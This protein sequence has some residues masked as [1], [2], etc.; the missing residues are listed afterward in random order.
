MS[1]SRKEAEKLSAKIAPLLRSDL[2]EP[3][4]EAL[5]QLIAQAF[6]T[7]A[8][9]QEKR[10]FKR[11]AEV[12]ASANAHLTALLNASPAVLYSRPASGDLAPTFV[13]DG[14][15]KM[16][17]CTPREYLADPFFWQKRVAPDDIERIAAWVS[18]AH[19][20]DESAI[21]YRV[22]RGDGTHIWLCD[23]QH[24]IRDERGTPVEVVGSWTDITKR[25]L[26]EIELEKASGAA[27]A[28]NEAK[29][30]FLAN[31]SHEIRTPMNAVIGLSHLALNTDLAPR[32]RD[33]M[34]KIKSS[35]QHLLG[36]IN[37]ILDFSKI[38]AGKLSLEFVDFQLDSVLGN[39]GNLMSEKAWAKGLELIFDVAPE[40]C[41]DLKG[42]PLRLGQV[43][44]NFVSN[45]VKFTD[46]GEILV[47]VR[48]EDESA[49]RQMLAFSVT[50]TGIGM[51]HEEVQRLFEA[52]EQADCS[53]TRRHGG[54]G[55]GLAIA[56]QIAELM[57]GAVSVESELGHG[58]A[59]HFT[60][61]MAKGT[62]GARPRVLQ[63]DLLG[64]RVLV[65]DD[66]DSARDVISS[67]LTNMAFRA[68]E[69]SSGEAAVGMVRE[70]RASGEGYDLAFIDW[71]MPGLDGIETGRRIRAEAEGE[72]APHLVMITAYGREEVVGKAE[73]TGFAD[74][75]MKPVTSSNL[76]DAAVGVLG[77]ERVAAPFPSQADA[78]DLD[79]L[80][81]IRVLLV[82]DN[83]I[84]QEVAA[85]QLELADILVDIAD[86]GE[87]ALR[88][89]V[90]N[91]YD[92]VLMDMQM[93]VMDG[94]TA[95]RTLRKDS[96]YRDLPVI[97][98]TANAL[99]SDREAC[100]EAGMNDH[101]TKPINPDALF[102][103]LLR[104]VK[105]AP[106]TEL[107]AVAEV[108]NGGGL[109]GIDV[110][111]I[112]LDKGLRLTG[113]SPARYLAL[114]DKFVARQGGA[115]ETIRLALSDGDSD[116]A[117]REA[118]SLKGAAATL[119]IT[120]LADVASVAEKAIKTGDD[121]EEALGRLSMMLDPVV[122][123]IQ[124]AFVQE[125][126][127]AAAPARNPRDVAEPLAR[128]KHLL[129]ND[130]GEA[131]DF[132]IDVT[133]QLSAVLTPAEVNALS[134]HVSQFDFEAALQSL[135]GVASRLSLDLEPGGR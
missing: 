53:S 127:E 131:A 117:E 82:E 115:V 14:V 3:D 18:R 44:I 12:Q 92:A 106:S 95:T 114:L 94:V 134:D 81:G 34:Q 80:R 111:G 63:S 52:F 93:P 29:S 76:F 46:K 28:A 33:Y 25:K 102:S 67:M 121:T 23:R 124:C 123:A 51:T 60:V 61:P 74:V 20:S 40:V 132:I 125:G 41:D 57:G 88:L 21:E 85:G 31:M 36:I 22:D 108:E 39:V 90:R 16:F 99:A 97:A 77:G 32:Q 129:E 6:D 2:N 54:T 58:S 89:I 84:N 43:L 27:M 83:E 48:V 96:R 87:E 118:H 62:A 128:L 100:L 24:V 19:E 66:N 4:R 116:T 8:R 38:E 120:A 104:W 11:I 113:S 109:A 26:A 78:P 13:S 49:D 5:T 37:D 17:G 119:G 65:V 103:A 105:P 45:A 69:A 107:P 64:R 7:A 42:D 35:A 50:D 130:D 1:G 10:S 9:E 133:P 101:V 59:F 70:A 71:R 55:L 79:R 73:E 91:D 15:T 98:M 110:K 86:N 135:S 75:L 68:D 47:K 30:A 122:K 112:D 56:K 126:H 72:P